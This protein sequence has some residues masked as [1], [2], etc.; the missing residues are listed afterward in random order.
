MWH[1]EV[2][3]VAVGSGL[4]GI[5]AAIAAHE[6]GGEVIVL[7]KAPKL[8]GVCAYSGGEV[9]VC[10]NH[11]MEA[12]GKP[13]DPVAARAYLD[14]LAGGYAHA[15]HQDVLFEMGP[16]VAKWVAE[17]AGVQWQ[18]IEDFPD[19]HYPHAPGT[20]GHGR[21]LEPALFDG[22]LL[23]EWRKKSYTTPHMPPG[24]THEELFAWGSTLR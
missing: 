20:V 16:V 8:G 10:M 12:E 5:T 21:Y 1:R 13:D 2:D 6:A 17:H 4:G 24:I 22:H 9:F 14:F 23:G 15:A 19:Y 11:L 3:L 7:E 18:I